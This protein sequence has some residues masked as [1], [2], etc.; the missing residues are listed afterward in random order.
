MI[1]W[2]IDI[3]LKRIAALTLSVLLALPT[4]KAAY[5]IEQAA[6]VPAYMPAPGTL[7]VSSAAENPPVLRGIK[8]RTDKPFTFDLILDE[9]GHVL[10]PEARNA[11]AARLVRYFLAGITVPADQLWVNLSPY[12][13]D[14]VV[15][16]S[17][18]GTDLGEDMLGEDY[19]L[20]Q[21]AASLTDPNT[22]LG[23]RY[24]AAVGA[25][26]GVAGD[27]LA[28]IWIVPQ[29]ATVYQDGDKAF[30]TESR[31]KVECAPDANGNVIEPTAALSTILP[32]V[33]HE[34]N[35]G[36]HFARVRQIYHSLLLAAWYKDRLKNSVF[37]KVYAD[38]NKVAGVDLTDPSVKDRIYEQYIASFKKGAYDFVK[39]ERDPQTNRLSKRQYFSGGMNLEKAVSGS[40]LTK[41]TWSN[42]VFTPFLKN[43][44]MFTVTLATMTLG[45]KSAQAQMPPQDALPGD[46]V[47]RVRESSSALFMTTPQDRKKALARLV[48]A[49]ADVSA[50]LTDLARPSIVGTVKRSDAFEAITQKI[51]AYFDTITSDMPLDV[52]PDRVTAYKV[53]AEEVKAFQADLTLDRPDAGLAGWIV[54]KVFDL[55]VL[56]DESA[57]ARKV[58]LHQMFSY[59]ARRAETDG[60]H[61]SVRI[62]EDAAAVTDE[63]ALFHGLMGMLDGLMTESKNDGIIG[64]TA[65]SAS[66]DDGNLTLSVSL[67]HAA[68][69]AARRLF[70]RAMLKRTPRADAVD[71][72]QKVIDTFSADIHSACL[73]EMKTVSE[74]LRTTYT[75]SLP[76]LVTRPELER[77]SSWRHD[78][79]SAYNPVVGILDMWQEHGVPLKKVAD[80]ALPL[81]D[82]YQTLGYIKH[83]I[84]QRSYAQFMTHIAD[85]SAKFKSDRSYLAVIPMLNQKYED[86]GA[87]LDNRDFY[88][89]GL[90]GGIIGAASI[91]SDFVPSND[92]AAGEVNVASMAQVLTHRLPKE[93]AHVLDAL[94]PAITV[95][96]DPI[97]LFR[98]FQNIFSNAKEA[99]VNNGHIGDFHFSAAT[100]E[101]GSVV[102]MIEDTFGGMP[103]EI[104]ATAR[105]GGKSTKTGEGHGYGLANVIRL[106]EERCQ[107]RVKLESVQKTETTKGGTRYVITLPQL[108]QEVAAA[109]KSAQPAVTKRD[110]PVAIL[111]FGQLRHDFNNFKNGFDTMLNVLLSDR[112]ADVSSL[113][114]YRQ[115]MHDAHQTLAQFHN[116][117]SLDEFMLAYEQLHGITMKM[118]DTFLTERIVS[119]LKKARASIVGEQDAADHLSDISVIAGSL[120][121]ARNV[122]AD[123]FPDLRDDM[124][125][126]N[127]D[128]DVLIRT[129]ASSA[130]PSFSKKLDEFLQ[131]LMV[132]TDEI[133]LARV[134]ENVFQNAKDVWAEREGEGDFDVTTSKSLDG[135]VTIV[136]SDTFGGMPEYV[137][138]HIFDTGFTTKEKGSGF[139]LAIAKEMIEQRCKGTIS[140]EST[141]GVGTTFTITV[142][143][144]AAA[145]SS[146]VGK[147]VGGVKMDLTKASVTYQ[148]DA[149]SIDLASAVPIDFDVKN[150]AGFSPVITAMRKVRE[151]EEIFAN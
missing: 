100:Q 28:K 109:K 117:I 140:V 3:C 25:E 151:G 134:L 70:D 10:T 42:A 126:H 31:L 4:D 150:F 15:P 20:K 133:A 46:D 56:S 123:H 35:T 51:T 122:L 107:G 54:E 86:F 115:S 1:V 106:I 121:M 14:R 131:P 142:P 88:V 33:E 17:L 62:A 114:A 24:W 144:Q 18:G 116:G 132:A 32:A 41:K 92:V 37:A 79:G 129:L 146:A 111:K 59:L 104:L 128:I 77:F 19:V 102:L 43:A 57:Q 34:V 147:D 90:A 72:Y 63:R 127:V 52:M 143:T 21:F 149:V 12:E 65:L 137:K 138:K 139:G 16:E 69:G 61:I 136:I 48:A 135:T 23:K 80:I 36:A 95:R 67:D 26:G 96:T 5:A 84:T 89:N 66:V 64:L 141:E 112:G 108:R 105:Q 74:G 125:V 78:F 30:V 81:A 8:I 9:A 148:G 98:V 75:I 93:F 130:P 45:M 71:R 58:D 145:T 68:A 11:E 44:T 119:D 91:L 76:E 6:G 87:G 2:R 7:L 40:A 113:K 27:A 55:V 103:K 73:S 47:E 13:A 120:I 85:L 99:Y 22:D 60:V 50:L 29:S 39:K 49:K 118:F 94:D 124:P 83:P 38:K 110:L 97:A 53:L 101:D 82:V